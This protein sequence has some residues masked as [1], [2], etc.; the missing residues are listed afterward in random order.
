[1]TALA[2][3]LREGSGTTGQLEWPDEFKSA[4]EDMGGGDSS[5][6]EKISFSDIVETDYVKVIK[7]HTRAGDSAPYW[8]GTIEYFQSIYTNL[9]YTEVIAVVSAFSFF[10]ALWSIAYYKSNTTLIA[11]IKENPR[12]W[13][14]SSNNSATSTVI[15]KSELYTSL[16]TYK[17]LFLNKGID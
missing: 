3:I 2:D 13:L 8:N 14:L 15:S 12:N 17:A 4:A 9:T 6:L 1:M 10:A 16:D 11:E 7:A 5:P